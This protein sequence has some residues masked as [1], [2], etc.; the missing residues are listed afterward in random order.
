MIVYVYACASATRPLG[1]RLQSPRPP[2]GTTMRAREMPAHSGG[3]RALLR[4]ADS[5]EKEEEKEE[6]EEEGEGEDEE[7]YDDDDDESGVQCIV[8]AA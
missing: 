2:E 5:P 8:A 3:V 7:D 4:D 1:H 6:E